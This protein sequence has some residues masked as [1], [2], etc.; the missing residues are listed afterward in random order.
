[1]TQALKFMFSAF[2]FIFRL[3]TLF[4]VLLVLVLLVKTVS[5]FT[6]GHLAGTSVLW[7]CCGGKLSFLVTIGFKMSAEWLANCCVPNTYSSMS[8]PRAGDQ[9]KRVCL[10]ATI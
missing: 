6:F 9:N 2:S 1:M 10:F 5:G 8:N 4:S 7:V 3:V